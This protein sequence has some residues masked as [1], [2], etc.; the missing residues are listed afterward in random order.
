MTDPA[1]VLPPVARLDAA[2]LLEELNQHAGTRLEY[3]GAASGGEVGAAFVRWP[4]GRQGVLTRGTRDLAAQQRTV[5]FLDI[6][7]IHGIPAPR[8]DLI[9]TLPGGTIVV[10]QERLPGTPPRQV[11]DALIASMIRINDRCANLFPD[12]PP[13]DLHLMRSGLGYC[14]HESLAAYDDRTRRLLEWVHQVGR[15]SGET[16]PGSDLV[17]SDF[18]PGNV[19]VD[20]AGDITGVID[21]GEATRGDRHFALITL[22]FD[23]GWR[24]RRNPDLA[25]AARQQLADRLDRM[26]PEVL[27]LGWAHMSLRLV[28]WAIRH[29]S[30]EVVDHYL[31]FAA[32]RAEF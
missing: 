30:A 29:Y 9:H 4:D 23:L 28:D 19:L 3:A 8:Y 21:W 26:D 32:T 20:D 18:H 10:I 6:A 2:T 12:A 17:H 25:T 11:D 5:R 31:A 24:A 7:R 14:L 15:E 13:F 1:R 16:L 22:A 27:R